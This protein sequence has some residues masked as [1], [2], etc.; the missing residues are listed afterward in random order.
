[1]PVF[2]YEVADPR[3]VLSRGRAEAESQGDDNHQEARGT[4]AA[5]VGQVIFSR[6]MKPVLILGL[7]AALKRR[8]STGIRG[9]CE[10]FRNL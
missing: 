7:Y 3:G 9:I 4:G 10:F 6:Y 8:S 1:M 5:T 2:E